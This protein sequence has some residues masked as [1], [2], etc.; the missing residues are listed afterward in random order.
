MRR[1]TIRAADSTIAIARMW[2]VCNRGMSQRISCT[3]MLM[4][5]L[6]SHSAKACIAFPYF[7]LPKYLKSRGDWP[8]RVR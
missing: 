5:V 2:T 8:S 7:V 3:L 1:S 4:D 6:A